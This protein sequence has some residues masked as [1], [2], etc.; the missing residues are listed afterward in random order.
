MASKIFINYRRNDEAG[1]ALALQIILEN[2]FSTEDVFMDVAGSIRP[3]DDF[4]EVIDRG[5]GS[6]M[7]LLSVIG[8]D[9]TKLLNS[10]R[11]SDVDFVVYEITSALNQG[12]RVV[13]VL[14]NDVSM[15]S[16]NEV[17]DGLKGFIVRNAFRLRH[18][19]FRSDCSRLADILKEQLEQLDNIEVARRSTKA[20][21]IAE[22][23]KSNFE[24]ALVGTVWDSVD[25]DGDD[26]VF[27]FLED[28]I[29]EYTSPTGTYDN[30]RWTQNGSMVVFDMNEHHATYT[31]ELTTPA[32]LKGSAE[33]KEG[34]MWTFT[35]TRR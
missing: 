9:W 7:I 17:P 28:G 11:A 12:K 5:V 19:S 32:V 18:D 23:A 26:Y 16:A 2:L 31:A 3:G 14:L 1:Y 8:K 33:N 27:R 25:S 13:P 34:H 6:S 29:L 20:M 35:G 15:P 24:I 21:R 4:L 22:S 30:G 10:P